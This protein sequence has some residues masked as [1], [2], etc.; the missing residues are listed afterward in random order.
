MSCLILRAPQSLA[1]S[2]PTLSGDPSQVKL[3][4]VALGDKPLAQGALI[5]LHLGFRTG[6]SGQGPDDGGWPKMGALLLC[7]Q[8]DL[9][10]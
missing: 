2:F 5:F 8:V 4:Q 10:A 3:G 1:S 7:S 9:G 6:S